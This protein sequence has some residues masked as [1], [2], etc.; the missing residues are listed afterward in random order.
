MN[1][2]F[3]RILTKVKGQSFK[4]IF[5]VHWPL[6]A[7]L[8][9]IIIAFAFW[10]W[11]HQKVQ[12]AVYESE[13]I[14]FN[15]YVANPYQ[16][17]ID[18]QEWVYNTTQD[19]SYY[20]T[21][22]ISS[23]TDWVGSYIEYNGVRD[24][25]PIFS[26]TGLKITWLKG[27]EPISEAETSRLWNITDKNGEIKNAL[28]NEC[29]EFCEEAVQK[30]PIH[31]FAAGINDSEGALK[32]KILYYLFYPSL[33]TGYPGGP[34]YQM[35]LAFLDEKRG[36]WIVVE[37]REDYVNTFT[38]TLPPLQYSFIGG[39]IQGVKLPELESPRTI[40][41]RD[42]DSKLIYVQGPSVT[43]N[44]SY[45]GLTGGI[46]DLINN[47]INPFPDQSDL[48]FEEKQ[49]S[50]YRVENCYQVVMPDGSIV[51]Y[52]LLPY[53][54]R[55][56]Y[57]SD[58]YFFETGHPNDITW[59]EGVENGNKLV[60]IAGDIGIKCGH[61]ITPCSNVV[62]DQKWFDESK[63]APIGIT[64]KGEKIFEMSDA[65]NNEYY[66]IMFEAS[67]YIDPDFTYEYENTSSEYIEKLNKLSA[68]AYTKFVASHPIFFW[69]DFNDKWR[70]YMNSQYLSSAECGKPV[71]Y[72]YPEKEMNV[73]VQVRPNGGFT[74]TEPAY[75]DNGWVVRA[76]PDSELYNYADSI[77]YPYL[78]WEGK[79]YD[80]ET[81]D[82]GYVMNR[83]EVAGKMPKILA[84][85]GLNEK[86]IKDFLEFW[87]PKLEVKPYVFVTFIPQ[88][89]FD[90]LAPLTVY[91]RPHKVIRVFMDYTMLDK[92]IT[93]T[94]PKFRTPERTG[95]TVVEW[96]GRLHE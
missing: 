25:T 24:Y 73:N 41:L 27:A 4:Q 62:N 92:P 95:F 89:E 91:P 56:T 81:P 59:D 44:Y 66:R 93:A 74:K 65:S 63:L 67:G 42:S 51:S 6:I 31:I 30:S 60:T 69:K 17:L 70:V 39:A 77:S 36:K 80:M 35:N 82:Y 18:E 5:R 45:P 94:E 37:S 11:S 78:F 8:P 53:F 21:V 26:K 55:V 48:I 90:R 12:D 46:V 29:K 13:K 61:K 40:N 34:G 72:L 86:E 9:L 87:Q 38:Y 28:I 54:L 47:K 52:D 23:G 2:K 32:N 50:V 1:E 7:G 33:E 15:D 16:R 10:A 3:E 22:T 58:K 85:L 83:A 76:T 84:N 71:I 75:P 96:G 49:Y 68:N 19:S 43:Y 79:A 14:S 64:K 57:D 20:P 88:R